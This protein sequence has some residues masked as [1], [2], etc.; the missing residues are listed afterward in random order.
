M[1]EEKIFTGSAE[2]KVKV[3]EMYSLTEG[4]DRKKIAIMEIALLLVIRLIER[5]S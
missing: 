2:Q 1:F 3:M 5:D 4:I